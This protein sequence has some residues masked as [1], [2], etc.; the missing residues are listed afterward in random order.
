MFLHYFLTMRLAGLHCRPSAHVKV[1][2]AHALL[3]M[4]ASWPER[5]SLPARPAIVATQL[6]RMFSS[7]HVLRLCGK[8]RWNT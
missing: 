8:P 2:F 1:L 3:C 7:I 6:A 5:T 4:H